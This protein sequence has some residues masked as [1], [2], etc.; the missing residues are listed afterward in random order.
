MVRCQ[1]KSVSPKYIAVVAN[2]KEVILSGIADLDF[3]REHLKLHAL[4]PFSEDGRAHLLISATKLTW[5][6]M[7][8]RELTI[9]VAVTTREDA[10][11]LDGFY[12]AHA[13]NS[14]SM[15]A[16]MERAFFQ[17]PYYPATIEV[18]EEMPARFKLSQ[19]QNDWLVAQMGKPQSRPQR[20]D[21]LWQGAIFL[22]RDATS[23][24]PGNFFYASLGGATDAYPFSPSLD[25]FELKPQPDTPLRWLSDSNFTGKEWRIRANATHARSKTFTI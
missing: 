9:S 13:S 3:W 8:S 1:V 21:E 25:T 11:T 6:S 4:V 7:P 2:I 19:A 14:S 15:L 18:A 16:W 12:L 22:P 5:M 23:K 10:N 24:Q 20:A 17:T